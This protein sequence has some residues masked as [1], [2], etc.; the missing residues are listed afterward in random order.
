MRARPPAG[1]RAGGPAACPV[2]GER[3]LAAAANEAEPTRRAQ[4]R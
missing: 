1:G 4:A 3:S 2:A